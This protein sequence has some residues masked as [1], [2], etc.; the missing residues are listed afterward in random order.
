MFPP[1]IVLLIELLSTQSVGMGELALPLSAFSRYVPYIAADASLV[2]AAILCFVGTANPGAALEALRKLREEKAMARKLR[3]GEEKAKKAKARKPLVISKKER[4]Q[5]L[6]GEMPWLPEHRAQ[7]KPVEEKIPLPSSRKPEAPKP[8]ES[9]EEPEFREEPPRKKLDHGDVDEFIRQL[10]A[11]DAEKRIE[12]AQTLGRMEDPKGLEP[13]IGALGDPEIAVREAAA[14]AL[15]SVGRY[16]LDLL[17]I[18]HKN[19]KD[20]QKKEKLGEIITALTG[21]EE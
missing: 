10:H 18:S 12:A 5:E 11:E 3:E 16:D 1:V 20:E 8:E 2:A 17:K 13:L 7:R 9:L 6:R 4:E 15:E 21:R 19:E 14:L